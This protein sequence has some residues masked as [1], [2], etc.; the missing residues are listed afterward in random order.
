MSPNSMGLR[1]LI[2]EFLWPPF[3]SIIRPWLPYSIKV[4]IKTNETSPKSIA[5]RYL[6]KNIS[7]FEI[8]I[9][10]DMSHGNYDNTRLAI[11]SYLAGHFNFQK[12]GLISLIYPPLLSGNKP[13]TL[14]IV[15]DTGAR[16]ILIEV[17]NATYSASVVTHKRV[18]RH[19]GGQR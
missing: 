12:F 1:R 14:S 7:I 19:W 15:S 17:N 13:V 9:S 5:L 8:L 4:L 18:Q 2:T 16:M 3:S 10:F 11:N 6:I